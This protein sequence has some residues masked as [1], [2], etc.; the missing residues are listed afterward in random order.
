MKKKKII[1]ILFCFTW[2]N[3]KKWKRSGYTKTSIIFPSFK[4][5]ERYNKKYNN[6]GWK[7]VKNIKEGQFSHVKT[8]NHK[9][10]IY[11]MVN[12]EVVEVY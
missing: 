4:S 1:K 11:I 7:Y 3:N 9:T 2:K 12:N 10:N 5:W 8:I 6:E